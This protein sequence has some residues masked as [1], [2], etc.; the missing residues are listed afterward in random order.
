MNVMKKIINNK[1]LPSVLVIL[2]F[3]ISS[4]S[5]LQINNLVEYKNSLKDLKYDKT[6][7][8]WTAQ[9][10]RYRII[11]KSTPSQITVNQKVEFN[12]EIF[13]KASNKQVLLDDASIECTSLMPD[14]PGYLR[15]LALYKQ[16]PVT[17]PGVCTLLPLS[18]DNAGKWIVV[19]S[20]L[21]KSGE[22]FRIDFPIEVK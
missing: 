22:N 1:L 3:S 21:L 14:T 6:E 4:C 7:D 2:M 15:V 19:Y 5:H 10:D 20:I 16:Y 18:F 11:F 12:L 17:S 8:G 13:D 9:D